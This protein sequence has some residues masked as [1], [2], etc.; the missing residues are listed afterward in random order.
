MLNEHMG[1]SCNHFGSSWA[2]STARHRAAAWRLTVTI[3]QH[4]AIFTDHTLVTFETCLLLVCS[5]LT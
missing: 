3:S 5:I 4:F 1:S 2:T